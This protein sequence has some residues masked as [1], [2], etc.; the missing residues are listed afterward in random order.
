MKLLKYELYKVITRKL[1]WGFLAAV[2]IVNVAALLWLNRPDGLSHSETKAMFDAIRTM[3]RD[4]KLEYL[5]E[6]KEI[7]GYYTLKEMADTERELVA[8]GIGLS[9]YE[10][11]VSYETQLEEMRSRF[12]ERLDREISGETASKQIDLIDTVMGELTRNDYREYLAGIDSTAEMNKTLKIYGDENT[13]TYRNIEKTQADFNGMQ[14]VR[15]RYDVNLGLNSLFDSPPTDILLII[16]ITIVCIALIT[17]EKD[18][19]LFLLIKSTPGGVGRTIA[20]KMGA[21]A[22]C[23]F[24]V[25]LIVFLSNIVFAE[26]TFGLGDMTRPIQSIPDMMIST[27]KINLLEFTALFFLVKVCGLIAVGLL[28]MFLAI[29]ARHGII[30]LL[31]IGI[32]SAL[33]VLLGMIPVISSWNWLRFL[34]FAMLIRP[35]EVLRRYFNLSLFGY[36]VG[37]IPIFLLFVCIV[38]ASVLFAVCFSYVKKRGLENSNALWGKRWFDFSFKK[39][40]NWRWFE[41]RKIA[42]TNRAL[43]ILTVFAIAQIFLYNNAQPPYL[44]YEHNY[45]KSFLIANQGAITEP[46]EDFILTEKAKLDEAR[47]ETDKL[48]ELYQK[49]ELRLDEMLELRKQYDRTLANEHVINLLY[50]RYEYINST[51][52]AEFLYDSGY[53]ELFGLTNA[54]AGLTSGMTLVAVLA[55]CLCGVF[56][57]EYK[58]GMYKILNTAKFGHSQTIKIKL[59]FSSIFSM[60]IFICAYLPDLLYIKNHYGFQGLGL[61][62]SSIPPTE[63]G[64]FPVFM[65]GLPVWGYLVLLI[66]VRFIVCLGIA[67]FI[68]AFSLVIRNNLYTVLC[69]LG[70][71]LAPLLFHVFDITFLDGVS[72]YRLVT[73]NGL[74]TAYPLWQTI[75]G[76]VVFAAGALISVL[77]LSQ[78]FGRN[79]TLALR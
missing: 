10:D 76:C 65:G 59:L 36:P 60:M 62:L 68:L 74:F 38:F 58:T 41:F 72:L 30:V 5:T 45:I 23:V 18:K 54:D 2:L 22:L 47:A 21:M 53:A 43:L 8:K 20:A 16:L 69:A 61:P 31:G 56:S 50:E 19:R 71:L 51:P 63:L 37:L 79:D 17:D 12:G 70:V 1:F 27:M 57:I 6:Q 35:Y 14:D 32:F 39:P 26:L 44:G 33:N 42:F 34:N 9:T 25:S 52:G 7:L 78:R 11:I 75:M 13:F 40:I 67:L 55:M 3:P 24:G 29:H 73:A 66:F 64:A 77:F 4:G 46:S 28:V 48:T 49:G 15:V